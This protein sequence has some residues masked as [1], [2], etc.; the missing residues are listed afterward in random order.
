MVE[1]EPDQPPSA[2]WRFYNWNTKEY[3]SDESLSCTEFHNAPTCH[4]TIRLSGRAK[5]FQ[6]E[7][8]GEYESTKMIS[9]GRTVI[10]IF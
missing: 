6:G 7:C 10:I 5:E 1:D 4:L 3:D 9:V 8:D 2:G